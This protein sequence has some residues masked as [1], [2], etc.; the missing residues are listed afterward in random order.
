MRWEAA[1]SLYFDD[2]MKHTWKGFAE[3]RKTSDSQGAWLLVPRVYTYSQKLDADVVDAFCV[4]QKGFT[5]Q[6]VYY[7]KDAP[8]R[9]LGLGRCI[10]FPSMA[11]FE[12]VAQGPAAV[13]PILF[14]FNRFDAENPKPADELF[15]SFPRLRFMLPEVVLIEDETGSY[16]QVN[17]LGPVYEGRAARFARTAAAAP[18]RSRRTIPF[19]LERDSRAEWEA[20]VAA[21]LAAISSRAIDKVVL[22]RRQKIIAD[23]PFSSKDL[24]VNLIDGD[25][26]GTV[27]LYRYGDVFFCGCTPELLVR[28][29]GLS[30]ES[31][32]L[33]GTIGVGA[34]ED[35]RARL[36]AELLD[37][38]KNRAEHEYVVDF[39]RHV[40][41]R[42]C[43][44]V[45]IPTEPT[46]KSL[47]HVQHLCTPVAA[48]IMDGVSIESLADQLHP[49]PALA[50]SPVGEALMT[51]RRIEAYNRGFFGGA[52]GYI[53]G[54]GDGAFSVAIRSGVFDGEMGWVYAGCG[55][56]EGSEAA[57]EFDEIDLKLKT[58]LSAFD[59]GDAHER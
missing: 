36:A 50:G 44:D 4:L 23:A 7:D 55:I 27:F 31:M 17:S 41:S 22:S 9:Y 13:A 19:S 25:A 2:R 56:V 59:G 1:A 40:I 49:T 53:D 11:D 54:D 42:N 5:D 6:F 51:I 26:R 37:D 46:I 30:I 52:V 3:P 10:A 39:M 29:K 57:S 45:A 43:Y 33:A 20:A 48:R 16:L 12:Y 35:E 28:K 47:R 15:A 34:D 38:A 32:C 14:S 8:R 21:G 24:L 58:I 18:A